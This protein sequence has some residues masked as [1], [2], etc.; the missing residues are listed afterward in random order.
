MRVN[1]RLSEEDA[2]KLDYLVKTERKSVTE[3]VRLSIHRYYEQA[4]AS[5]SA[6]SGMLE[7]SGFIGCA[8]GERDLSGTYKQRLSKSLRAKHGYR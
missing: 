7:R 2:K 1:A 8:E 3:I 6:A 5:H 4:R